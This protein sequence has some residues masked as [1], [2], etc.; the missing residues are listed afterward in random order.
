[1]GCHHR[2]PHRLSDVNNRHLF[3]PF[4]SLEA[5]DQG[6]GRTGFS[7]APSLGCRQYLP[8]VPSSS[9]KDTSLDESGAPLYDPT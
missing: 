8:D 7:W 4:W 5:Q 2:I 3:V 1:M 6:V 9:D